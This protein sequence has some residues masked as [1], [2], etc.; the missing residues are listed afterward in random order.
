MLS[1]TAIGLFA[2]SG[3]LVMQ[4]PP[5]TG[6]KDAKEATSSAED[7][8][9]QLYDLVTF[10]KGA[11]PDWDAVRS[12]FLE[13][14]VVVLRTSRADTTIFSLEGFVQDF[15]SFIERA[16]VDETG[17]TERI[18]RL[19]AMEFGDLAHVLVLYEAHING[20]P[21]PP[22]SGVD[23]FQMARREGQWKIVSVVNEIPTPDRPVPAVLRD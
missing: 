18:V 7:V 17:F 5:P 22:Q 10:E 16:N 14:A 12:L 2:V 8:V 11:T 1:L 4:E 15:V 23:S 6:A 3:G 21:R 19:E 9:R 13:E 20:S